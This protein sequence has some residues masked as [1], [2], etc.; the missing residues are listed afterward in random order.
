MSH[1][2][3]YRKKIHYPLW[4]RKK[5]QVEMMRDR[6]YDI[7]DDEAQMI[8]SFDGFQ[9]YYD[10][11][12]HGNINRVYQRPTDELRV[13]VVYSLVNVPPTNKK[14]TTTKTGKSLMQYIESLYQS[15]KA[16][17]FILISENPVKNDALINGLKYNIELMGYDEL[18]IN[19]TQHIFSQQHVIMTDTEKADFL[20]DIRKDPRLLPGISKH[21]PIVRYL[22]ASSKDVIAIVRK[23]M[24]SYI[25]PKFYYFREVRDIPQTIH[26]LA[27]DKEDEADIE[28]DI[29]EDVGIMP[30]VE[31]DEA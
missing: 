5:T 27:V 28:E 26:G 9:E 4:Q 25:I 29:E 21:N 3:L 24:L 8:L 6:G 7:D 23:P 17:S 22:G 11:T 10:D 14:A 19:P 2:A 20:Q 16:D 30:D 31:A 18:A 13:M 12:I 1:P 15:D